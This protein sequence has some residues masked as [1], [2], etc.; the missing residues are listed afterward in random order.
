[1][2][3]G[4]TIYAMT[5]SALTQLVFRSKQLNEEAADD[6]ELPTCSSNAP[7][8]NAI[9]QHH[10]PTVSAAI[11]R[12]VRPDE[13]NANSTSG[14]CPTPLQE[15]DTAARPNISTHGVCLYSASSS[16]L[17]TRHRPHLEHR[18]A[19]HRF[20]RSTSATVLHCVRIAL[21]L[22][23]VALTVSFSTPFKW[24]NGYMF[25]VSIQAVKSLCEWALVWCMA[26]QFLSYA[27]EFSQ[28]HFDAPAVHFVRSDGLSR[29]QVA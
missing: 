9:A 23:M 4:G 11:Q 24:G 16:E 2:F 13:S 26:L 5:Q 14:T 12:D 17:D 18:A 29:K 28:A 19:M 3:I 15:S 20:Y 10:L 27:H 21:T 22:A 25:G 7:V 6:V 1:M 8:Q